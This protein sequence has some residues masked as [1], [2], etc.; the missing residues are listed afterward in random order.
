MRRDWRGVPPPIYWPTEEK[1]S[2]MATVAQC[3]Y[4]TGRAWRRGTRL[5]QSCRRRRSIANFVALTK[6]H[7]RQAV[8]L[9]TNSDRIGTPSGQSYYV[10][11]SKH[12][13]HTTGWP[14]APSVG[15]AYGTSEECFRPNGGLNIYTGERWSATVLFDGVRVHPLINYSR[16]RHVFSFIMERARNPC[17]SYSV[18]Y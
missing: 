15:L 6:T 13:K 10:T 17:T 12:R 18:S 14:V 4:W 8:I 9:S 1:Q 11:A 5:K 3:T 2:S 16:G 7:K